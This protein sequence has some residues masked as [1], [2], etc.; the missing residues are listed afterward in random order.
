MALPLSRVT[1]IVANGCRV[2]KEY[3][4]ELK[5]GVD[6]KRAKEICRDCKLVK[7]IVKMAIKPYADLF[8]PFLPEETLEDLGLL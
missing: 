3:E 5:A 7:K 2:V 1:I 8:I 4:E 6:A